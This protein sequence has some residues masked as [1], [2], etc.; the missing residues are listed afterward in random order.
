[1]KKSRLVFSVALFS[2]YAGGASLG[3]AQ[4][5]GRFEGNVQT[6]WLDPEG[7]YRRMRLLSDFAYVDARGLKWTA[8]RGW[9][10]DGASI[11][12]AV[13]SVI[14]S[15]YDGPYR[16]AS[17]IHDV[18]CDQKNRPWR[19][20]HRTFY[21]AMRAEGL[22]PVKAKIMYAAVYAGGPRWELQVSPLVSGMGAPETATAMMRTV[23][24]GYRTAAIRISTQSAPPMPAPLAA[25]EVALV[26]EEIDPRAITEEELYLLTRRIESEPD[27]S[28]DAIEN[29][30]AN[31]G[32][33]GG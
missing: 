28:L 20:V 23:P 12:R 27:I 3:F 31:L 1:M 7:D 4:E 6:E 11:P 30:A 25:T 16:R 14:G 21:T 17:V 9:I 19:A 2:L 5:F 33:G 24:S 15:P 8:P 13:W 10:I 22:G 18:A 29:I 26:I 32:R